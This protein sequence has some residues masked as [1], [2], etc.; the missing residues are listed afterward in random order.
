MLDAKES[1]E[2][3][4]LPKD[5]VSKQY[6]LEAFHTIFVLVFGLGGGY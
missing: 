4:D 6:M 2:K 3:R 1:I 5:L